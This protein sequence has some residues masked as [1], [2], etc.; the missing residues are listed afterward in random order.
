[1]NKKNIE[2]PFIW[3]NRIVQPHHISRII[4]TIDEN[5]CEAWEV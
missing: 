2:A 4:S 3:K 1:M 5:L